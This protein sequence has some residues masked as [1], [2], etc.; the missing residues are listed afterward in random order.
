MQGAD[1]R[2]IEFVFVGG[3]PV[4]WNRTVRI[5]H[6]ARA[7]ELAA[8]LRDRLFAAAG[9]NLDGTW[10]DHRPATN[11]GTRTTRRPS[12]NRFVTKQLWTSLP[13]R[14]Q[15][16]GAGRRRVLAADL[17]PGRPSSMSC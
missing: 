13:R 7:Q 10:P 9:A 6:L 16:L 5:S 17:G 8:G 4:K 15:F 11:T 2:N 3:R 14:W 1:S 12:V